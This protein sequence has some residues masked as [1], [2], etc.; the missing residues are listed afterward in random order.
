M[1]DA[2]ID[3]VCDGEV[4]DVSVFQS[5][6]LDAET[7]FGNGGS[8]ENPDAREAGESNGWNSW[9]AGEIDE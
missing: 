2:S 3:V 7:N 4:I 6:E 1:L 8:L 9:E 5:A